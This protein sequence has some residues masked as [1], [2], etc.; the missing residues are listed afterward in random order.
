[1][2]SS[3]KLGVAGVLLVLVIVLVAQNTDPVETRLLFFTVTMP[4]AAL[5]V[6]SL[7]VGVVAGMALAARITRP[8]EPT[9]REERPREKAGA[10][11]P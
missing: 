10:R 2:W 6:I 4:R 5:M 1:M 3:I 11:G 9:A 8:G 7:L